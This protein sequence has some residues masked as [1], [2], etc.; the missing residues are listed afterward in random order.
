M[1]DRNEASWCEIRAE[2]VPILK[3]CLRWLKKNN[4][5]V[6]QYYTNAER[7]GDLLKTLASTVPQ[8]DLNTPMRLLR[9]S[10]VSQA[11]EH[12][13]G[14]TLH[15]ESAVLMILDP[16]QFPSSW[17]EVGE[18]ADVVGNAEL[19]VESDQEHRDV[20]PD[21]R[22]EVATVAESFRKEARVTL[23]DPHLDAKLFPH[24]HP[25]GSGSLHS[26]DGSGGIQQ[27]AK[28]RLLSLDPSFRNNAVWSFWMLDRLIKNDLYFAQRSR[29]K[30]F[31]D[32]AQNEE[33][34]PEA[35]EGIVYSQLFG[36]V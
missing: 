26:E 12:T 25:W 9:T 36:R 17:A 35:T 13:I 29:R 2:E 20:H 7:F 6:R 18:L 5:H 23:S 1:M 15:E 28:N 31:R 33:C 22:Q 32:E 10:R 14:D 11:V 4:P 3:E 27:F 21:L 34:A 30:R 8:G 24:L 19:R 16:D